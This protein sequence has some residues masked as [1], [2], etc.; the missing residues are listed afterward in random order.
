MICM[1]MSG[2]GVRINGTLTIMVLLLMVVPGKLEVALLESFGAAAGTVIP[3]I[4]GR[5]Y[6]T[7]S[8]PPTAAATS[9]SAS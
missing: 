9:V 3:R 7:G 8:F 4:A 1:E 5:H 6:A 2:N